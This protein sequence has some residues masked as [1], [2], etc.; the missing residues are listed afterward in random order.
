METKE[1]QVGQEE[2]KELVCKEHRPA[3]A[4]QNREFSGQLRLRIPK[5]LHARLALMAEKEGVSLNLLMVHLLSGNHR[6]RHLVRTQVLMQQT[7]H[8][9][10]NVLAQETKYVVVNRQNVDYFGTPSLYEMKQLPQVKAL[11]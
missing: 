9:Q 6:E 11:P 4:E 2:T 3:M 8:V 5:S 1:E 10:V 7:R